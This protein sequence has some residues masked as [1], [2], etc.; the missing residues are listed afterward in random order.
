ME[1]IRKLSSD[2]LY[3]LLGDAA[4][5]WLAHDGL[6]FQAVEKAYGLEA[7][8][9]LDKEAWAKFTV[10][11]AERIMKR[12]EI[13]PGGGI[14]ALVNALGY[15]LYAHLNEQEVTE[16]DEKHCV[17][18]MKT[19]RVQDARR[20]KGLAEFP[21]KPVGLVEYANFAST[22]DPRLVT[23]CRSCPPD[24]KPETHW[25]EWEFELK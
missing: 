8:I 14:P 13:N 7:A 9:A 5:N 21:C 18:R 11:E 17:F 20:K 2:K 22:I 12:L 6:W 4:K 25:C 24:P 10:V 3:D 19:C 1:E 23:T 15:R 16:Q